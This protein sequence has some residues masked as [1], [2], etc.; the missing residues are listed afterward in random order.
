MAL[1]ISQNYLQAINGKEPDV[2]LRKRVQSGLKNSC[3]SWMATTPTS[4]AAWVSGD[5]VRGQILIVTG[6][7]GNSYGVIWAPTSSAA[8]HAVTGATEPTWAT[9]ITGTGSSVVDGSG[10]W[11]CKWAASAVRAALVWFANQVRDYPDAAV[12]IAM[13]IFAID[14]GINGVNSRWRMDVSGNS[15]DDVYFPEL[16]NKMASWFAAI[17]LTA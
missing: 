5:Y 12:N 14:Y 13:D 15:I 7:G 1:T 6:S 9:A 10:S 8:T 3:M 11:T 2:Y 16:C 4:M 17:T